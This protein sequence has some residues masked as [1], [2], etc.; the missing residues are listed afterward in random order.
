MNIKKFP[1]KEK[2]P[3]DMPEFKLWLI[4][5][6]ITQAFIRD[7]TYLSR[8]TLAK[9]VNQGIASKP[10]IVLVSK[11]LKLKEEKL[12]KLLLTQE[13]HEYYLNLTTKD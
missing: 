4:K 9:M 13:N 6:K 3:K 8:G 12:I 5:K 2:C 1:T 11:I 10:N 7:E